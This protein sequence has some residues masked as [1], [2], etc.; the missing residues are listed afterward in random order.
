MPASTASTR[1]VTAEALRPREVQPAPNRLVLEGAYLYPEEQA[2]FSKKNFVLAI[3][4]LLASTRALALDGICA[5]IPGPLHE[6]EEDHAT[7][8]NVIGSP[9]IPASLPLATY[10][11]GALSALAA[12]FESCCLTGI[13]RFLLPLSPLLHLIPVVL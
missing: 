11:G 7:I 9:L 10:L 3:Q 13:L 2:E 12:A 1:P 5:S 8:R 6:A 4:R